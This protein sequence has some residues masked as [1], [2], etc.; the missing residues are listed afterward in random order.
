MLLATL[1]AT[2]ILLCDTDSTQGR[3]DDEQ[4]EESKAR[5]IPAPEF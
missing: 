3:D 5:S 4:G 2:S 1:L